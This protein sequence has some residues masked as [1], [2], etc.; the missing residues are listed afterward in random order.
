MGK[1]KYELINK[2]D[3]FTEW[4]YSKWYPL[5]INRFLVYKIMKEKGCQFKKIYSLLSKFFAINILPF[6]C[7]Y[8]KCMI[9]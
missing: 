8:R 2:S 6:T 7:L 9:L 4:N 3:I 5:I 1:F